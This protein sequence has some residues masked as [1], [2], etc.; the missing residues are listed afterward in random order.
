MSLSPIREDTIDGVSEER[1]IYGR[2]KST[3]ARSPDLIDMKISQSL[4][5]SCKSTDLEQV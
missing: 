4:T 3:P 1:G 5:A 2:G